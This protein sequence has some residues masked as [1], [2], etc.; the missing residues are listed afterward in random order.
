MTLPRVTGGAH[1]AP[2]RCCV[3]HC[4]Q[5]LWPHLLGHRETRHFHC[6]YDLLNVTLCCLG[7]E[8]ELTSGYRCHLWYCWVGGSHC[9]GWWVE[10]QRCGCLCGWREGVTGSC[11]TDTYLPVSVSTTA[12]GSPKAY[13]H[14][15]CCYQVLWGCRLNQSGWGPGV[16]AS[17]VLWSWSCVPAHL[18]LDIWIYGFSGI[19]SVLGRASLL[20]CGCLTGC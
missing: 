5:C 9:Y 11:V 3:S 4:C 19:L 13:G 14:L 15:F 6:S 20:S 12:A 17:P 16:W 8:R 2:E 1:C 10:A 18:P 7:E